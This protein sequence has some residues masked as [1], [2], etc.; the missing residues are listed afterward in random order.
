MKPKNTD[1]LNEFKLKR[2]KSRLVANKRYREKHPEKQLKYMK[3]YRE[4]HQ[5]EILARRMVFIALRGGRI[6]R[7]PCAVCGTT[8]VEAHHFDH[9]K[10]LEIIWLCKYHHSAEHKK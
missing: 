5:T 7:K 10:P 6:V 8:K 4:T 1:Y 9:M 3:N 2:Q